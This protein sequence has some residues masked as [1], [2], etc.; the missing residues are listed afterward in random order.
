MRIARDVT[1]ISA[2]SHKHNVGLYSMMHE[3]W[4][5]HLSLL[6]RNLSHSGSRAD[7]G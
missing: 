2:S 4:K 6:G 3:M 1:N 5:Q 7:G